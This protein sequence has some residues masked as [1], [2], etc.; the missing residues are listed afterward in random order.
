[1]KDICGTGDGVV[2]REAGDG[3]LLGKHQFEN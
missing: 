1:M 3:D 2:V